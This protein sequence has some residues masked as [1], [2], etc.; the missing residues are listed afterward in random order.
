MTAADIRA[1]RTRHSLTQRDLA[2]RLRVDVVTVSRWE[3]GVRS[4]D[5][6]SLERLLRLAKRLGQG[7]PI[8]GAVAMP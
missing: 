6:H 1:L 4:P 3:T 8:A 7:N 2:K 5:K